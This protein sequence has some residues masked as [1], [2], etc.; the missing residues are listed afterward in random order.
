MGCIWSSIDEEGRIGICKERKKVMK[1]LVNIR[2]EFSDSLLAYLKALRNTGAT[3]RQFTES[4]TLDFET[5]LVEPP[6]PPPHLPASPL[7]PPPRP[8]FLADKATALVAEEEILENDDNDVPTLQID[9]G[10]NSLRQFRHTDKEIV[11]S[12]EEESW[13]ETKTEFDDEDTRAEAAV[14]VEKSRSG[15]QQSIEPVYNNTSAMSL[16]RKETAAMPVVVCRRGKT[17]EGIV[18]ELDEYFLKASA[19]IKEIAVLIDISGGDTLLRQNSGHHNR[20]GSSAKVFSVLSWSRYSKSPHFTKDATEF[21]GPSEPCKPGAHCATL[22]K[23]Y[24]AEK[25]LFKAVKEE[26]IVT[27]EFKRK[28]SLLHKQED[29]NLELVKIDKTRSSVEKLKSHLV[30]IQQCISETT[31]SILE[32]IDEELL[33]QLVALIAGLAQMWRTM[34]ECHRAQALISQQLSN[35]SDNH[36]TIL[37]SEYHHHATIQFE[38]EASY[39]YNSFCKIVKSQKEYVTTLCKWIELTKH[40]RDGHECSDHSSILAICKQW[41]L[42]LNGLPDKEASDAIKSLLISIHSIIAQQ[43]EEDNILKKLEKLQRKLQKCSNSLGEMQKKVDADMADDADPKHPIYLKKAD[44]EAIEKQV[45]SVKANYVDSVQ[46]SKAMTLNY[47][48]TRLPDL[49]QSLMEFSSASAEAIEVI[50]TQSSQ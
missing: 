48:Q 5:A 27:L 14:N 16:Y 33:P 40:L 36:N 31:L 49:F 35:L 13:E 17:L 42:G 15:R 32:I 24:A 50:N 7:L 12:V 37:N 23:L 18:R 39:W 2:G 4:D 28:D 38:T 43:A 6:S 9:P 1:Q 8:P 21:S 20:R 22:K 45:E 3:L 30:S 44:K 11:E 10:M 46:Y 47:L 29:E 26:G 34:H 19:C 25:K 41:E